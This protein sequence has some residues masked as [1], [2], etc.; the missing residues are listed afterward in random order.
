MILFTILSIMALVVAAIAFIMIFAGGAAF[1]VIF[2]DII[3]FVAII[4][5]LVKLFR[6]KK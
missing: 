6:R 4:V 1:A 2:G 5:L 3:I